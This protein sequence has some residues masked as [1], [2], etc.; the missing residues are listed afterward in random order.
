MSKYI[1]DHFLVTVAVST[2][3]A[4]NPCVVLSWRSSISRSLMS[5]LSSQVL[6][7]PYRI[8]SLSWSQVQ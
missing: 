3:S 5:S 2:T 1:G 7:S 8:T 6:S 4:G